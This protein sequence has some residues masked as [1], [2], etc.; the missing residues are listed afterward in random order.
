MPCV[1]RSPAVVAVADESRLLTVLAVC[2]NHARFLRECLDSIRAQTW[3][4]FQLIVTDDGSV[5]GS[6]DLIRQWLERHRPDAT[7]IAHPRNRGL[8]ATLNEALAVVCGKYLAKLSTDDVWLPAKL[9]RQLAIMESLPDRVAVLYT[10]AY[11]IDEDSNLLPRRYLSDAVQAEPPP[12]G[13]VFLRVLRNNNFVLGV[14][15]LLRASCLRDVGGYDEDL[16][17]EDW[18]MWLR[19]ADRFDFVFSDEVYAQYREVQTSMS[20]TLV[21][22][23]SPGRAWNDLLI[24]EK[25]LPSPRLD[26]GTRLRT[27]LRMLKH[28]LFLRRVGDARAGAAMA[29]ALAAWT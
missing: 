27:R 28:A 10:D 9:E 23:G 14:T 5:D 6:A 11:Q 13:D 26:L 18:D 21:R 19:L 8:C 22:Y 1:Q 4:D 15:T 20:H 12:S 29:R 7:F 2:Y 3:Q 25:W 16:A 24:L 17:Y